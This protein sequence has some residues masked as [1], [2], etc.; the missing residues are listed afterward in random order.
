M[1]E[2][3]QEQEQQQPAEKEDDRSGTDGRVCVPRWTDLIIY[4]V[5]SMAHALA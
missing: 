1:Q 3:E 5:N 2:Q 4:L